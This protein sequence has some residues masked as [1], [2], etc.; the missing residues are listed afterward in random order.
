MTQQKIGF[1]GLGDM[2]EPMAERLLDAGYTV[3]SCANKTRTAIERLAQKGLMEV[4]TPKAVGAEADVLMSVVFSENQND[5][6]LRGPE[7]ALASLKPGSIVLVMSTI[8]PDYC[9]D[10]AKEA[11]EKGI[12]V[13]DCPLS[14]M[15]AGAEQGTLSLL[16][17]GDEESIAKCREALE[18]M[19]TVMPCGPLG[20][21]Q[22][23]KLANNALFLCTLDLLQ[24]VQDMVRRSGMDVELFMKHLNQSTGRSFV[25]QNIP[26]PKN[27]MPLYPM[28]EKDLTT[29]LQVGES[30][31]ADVSAIRHCVTRPRPALK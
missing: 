4:A 3:V 2:G 31:G 28:P 16:I 17:G 6:I 18:V 25:S 8:S 19:G 30:C 20:S 9:K 14:G 11:A 15:R 5:R 12:T 13:L 24:D 29:C 7:G 21:G 23:T 27:R 26:V 22:V 1:I 10:L